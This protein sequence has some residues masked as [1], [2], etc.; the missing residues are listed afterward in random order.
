MINYAEI[1]SE[2]LHELKG[3]GTYRYFLNVN[4]SAQHFPTFYFEDPQGEKRKAINFCSND[5]LA[6]SVHEEVIS[7]LSFVANRAGTGSGGTRNISGT[8]IYHRELE[9]ALAKLHQQEAALVFGSAYLAN[10]TALSV[11]GKLLTNAIFISD[12]YNHAS[13]IEGIKASGA[14]K[15][16]FKHNDLEDLEN[17]LKSIPLNQPKIIV[18]E[19]IY[20]MSGTVSPI[21]EIVLLAKKYQA[22]TYIDEVHAVGIYGQNGGGLTEQLQ[23]QNGIDIIN[24]TLAKGFGVLG[25]YIAGDQLIIDA[26]RSMG[27]GFIFTTSLPPAI[28]AA[29]K[30]SIELL[31][32][33][34][35]IRPLYQEKVRELRRLLELNKIS[36]YSND[37]HITPIP[38]GEEKRCKKISDLL[39]YEHGIYIQPIVYP[40]VKKGEACLRLT[41]TAKH[42]TQH[43]QTLVDALRATIITNSESIVIIK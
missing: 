30:K 11:M 8:T 4:K 18:F 6:M 42:D 22:L 23:V 12:E 25:G 38:I 7:K 29:A 13:I 36:Y 41:I 10:L 5:Y 28:C 35:H 26:I 19:S 9:N 2:K 16:I 37:T 21:L 31:K 20:S 27:S 17:V 14:A 43:F 40:T 24:G 39:L 33:D 34:Q 3:S 32:A 1:F 15:K